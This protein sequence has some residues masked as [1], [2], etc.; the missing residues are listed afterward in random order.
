MRYGR[1]SSLGQ[2]E[3]L[4]GKGQN[5]HVSRPKKRTHEAGQNRQCAG[6]ENV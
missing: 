4:E 6:V 3:V 2:E 5:V 1:G